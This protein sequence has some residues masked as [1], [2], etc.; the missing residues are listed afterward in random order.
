M[1]IAIPT[2]APASAE[3]TEH[4][5]HDSTASTKKR[6]RT[7][8]LGPTLYDDDDSDLYDNDQQTKKGKKRKDLSSTNLAS[9]KF[10]IL[11][12][13][14]ET[15]L[16]GTLAEELEILQQKQN[17]VDKEGA[18]RALSLSKTLESLQKDLVCPICYEVLLDPVSLP[19][20]H[21]FCKDCVDWWVNTSQKST[22]TTTTTTTP[23]PSLSLQQQ[24]Q[25]RQPKCPTCRAPILGL[26]DVD[27]IGFSL[28]VNTC[29][30]ACIV[31]L[32]PNELKE[33]IRGR[34]SNQKGENGGDHRH[35]YKAIYDLHE[36]KIYNPV[37]AMMMAGR[38]SRND[39]PLFLVRGGC[40][41]QRS[42]V[43]DA[44]DQCMRLC[45]AL[46]GPIQ[47]AKINGGSTNNGIRIEL[48]LVQL[49]E[50]EIE[51]GIPLTICPK[52][53]DAE[54]VVR[55]RFA[56]SLIDQSEVQTSDANTG[57]TTTTTTTTTT[58]TTTSHAGETIYLP[59]GRRQFSSEGRV[60]FTI[61]IPTE[62]TS[63][64]LFHHA[65]TGLKLKIVLKSP[66]KE[67]KSEPGLGDLPVDL[68]TEQDAN[69]NERSDHDDG[70]DDDDESSKDNDF[71]YGV[72]G[73]GVGEYEDDGFVIPDHAM[74]D[75]G[76]DD[77]SQDECA[78]CGLGGELLI[79]DGGDHAE[80]CKKCFHVQCIGL[81][82]I[83]DGDW[84]CSQC[85]VKEGFAT[86]S[87][88]G[89]KGYE[90]PANSSSDVSSKASSSEAS[91]SVEFDGQENGERLGNTNR[92][93]SVRRPSKRR[94]IEDSDED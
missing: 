49:E 75:D 24:Q 7:N 70:D 23:S 10:S 65:E 34:L 80:G 78:V 26:G 1:E 51:E 22:T 44:Q 53:D 4:A 88:N 43:M 84:I 73:R 64:F 30:R 25:R 6:K 17:E 58:I 77:K 38:A 90:F 54:F 18:T 2:P 48:C 37:R 21:S 20:G 67:S 74:D 94:V 11:G 32:Y 63:T 14:L 45:L 71:V 28:R 91:S 62:T 46:F 83:P 52:T 13:K 29:L 87:T 5:R 12:R 3:E 50:D 69:E 42:V 8:M 39:F 60:T 59:R 89:T 16:E 86:S 19:C 72:G 41:V 35:G 27:G 33:R 92:A 31:A 81:E 55:D 40:G 76:D 15:N 9:L 82:S 61:P 66:S 68:D 85:A 57:A 47:H 79:C 36:S 56:G 93:L